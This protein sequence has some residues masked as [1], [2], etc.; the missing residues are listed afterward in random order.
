MADLLVTEIKS[1][2]DLQMSG[3]DIMSANGFE[4]MPYLALFSGE[5]WWGNALLTDPSTKFV[6]QTEKAFRDVALTSAGRLRIE[7]AIKADLKFINEKMPGTVTAIETKLQ[8]NDRLDIRITINGRTWFYQW[9]PDTESYNGNG[10][11]LLN[12]V[13]TEQFTPEF[14]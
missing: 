2:G 7:A 8:D 4:S 11:D 5:S 9:N 10:K 3:N 14:T 1:N 6:S 12:G 13:F